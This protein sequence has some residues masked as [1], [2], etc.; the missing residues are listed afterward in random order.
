M[1]SISN[2]VELY[3]DEPPAKDLVWNSVLIAGFS[4]RTE[5]EDGQVDIWPNISL[6]KYHT[7]IINGRTAT[8]AAILDIGKYAERIVHIDGVVGLK[9]N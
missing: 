8:L 3:I 4:P 6:E 2:L 5:F 1:P 7:V 9:R